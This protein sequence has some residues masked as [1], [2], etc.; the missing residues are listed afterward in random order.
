MTLQENG[1]LFLTRTNGLPYIKEYPTYL[2]HFVTW[3]R[4][5][6]LSIRI[7]RTYPLADA[8][9]AHAAFEHRQISGRVL[10]FS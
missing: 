1:S 3:V 5:G 10:L 6:K 2:Q 4:E 7:H 8:A 9:L